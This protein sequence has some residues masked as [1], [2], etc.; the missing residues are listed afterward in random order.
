[1]NKQTVSIKEPEDYEN[2]LSEPD[3]N[4]HP[5]S[6]TNKDATLKKKNPTVPL[7]NRDF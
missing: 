3:L 6:T 2:M 7:Q 5:V 4:S 1:M